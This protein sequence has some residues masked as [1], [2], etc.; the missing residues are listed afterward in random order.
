M[1]APLRPTAADMRMNAA[2]EALMW[3]MARPGSRQP[4]AAPGV[5]PLAACLLDREASFHADDESLDRALSGTGARRAPLA[6]ADYVF[7]SLGAAAAVGR[8][9]RARVGS[10][11]YPDTAATIF[12]AATFDA[13]QALKL[14][15]PGVDGTACLPVAGVHP[16]FW[17]ARDSAARYPLGWD[18]YLVSGDEVVGIPRSTIVESP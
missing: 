16:S 2:F 6:Q 13:G 3:A 9:A 17:R 8:A 15:G 18:L 12:A 14:T 4:L 10:P 11:L 1:A 5:L 7:V